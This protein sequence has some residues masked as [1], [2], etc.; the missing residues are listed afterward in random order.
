[1]PC[2][3]LSPPFCRLLFMALTKDSRRA[4]FGTTLPLRGNDRP[5]PDSISLL[6]ARDPLLPLRDDNRWAAQHADLPQPFVELYLQG[7]PANLTRLTFR[8]HPQDCFFAC[9]PAGAL[10]HVVI[11]VVSGQQASP[12]MPAPTSQAHSCL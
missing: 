8:Q 6:A 11:S 4:Y 7:R 5:K 10:R 9:V 2:K 12:F 1:M 3:G